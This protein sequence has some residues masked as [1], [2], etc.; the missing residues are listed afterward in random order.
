MRLRHFNAVIHSRRQGSTRILRLFVLSGIWNTDMIESHQRTG[1]AEIILEWRSSSFSLGKKSPPCATARGHATT[2]PS[3][4]NSAAP[5]SATA[6]GDWLDATRSA[7]TTSTTTP[8]RPRSRP[9]TPDGQRPIPASPPSAARPR[10]R[11][12]R[13][14]QRPR[15][16]PVER[17]HIDPHGR[18]LLPGRQAAPTPPVRTATP[19]ETQQARHQRAGQHGHQRAP[20]ATPHHR[21][22]RH[23]NQP[24]SL[25]R[26]RHKAL[27]GNRE[28]LPCSSHE[29]P[30]RS[31][32][33]TRHR[34]RRNAPRRKSRHYTGRNAP[35][36]M[37]QETLHHGKRETPHHSRR[38][39]LHRS[40]HKTP[41]HS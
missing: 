23:A 34:S 26:G 31:K 11:H 2:P 17:A 18:P 37:S 28:T 9:I 40:M 25:H 29:T 4:T 20:Q 38:G 21:P 13:P 16:H 15:R 6:A 30:H 12:P 14:S 5:T 36:R 10:T 33:E 3:E 27:R 1:S 24:Q 22:R 19:Q 39:T 32:H 8:S 35:H 7:C 41:R